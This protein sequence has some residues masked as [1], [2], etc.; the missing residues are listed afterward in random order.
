MV[1]FAIWYKELYQERISIWLLLLH[2]LRKEQ[3]YEC[4]SDDVRVTLSLWPH[5][6]WNQGLLYSYVITLRHTYFSLWW[7]EIE[8][9]KRRT[10]WG[11]CFRIPSERATRLPW[12]CCD[13]VSLSL[14]RGQ[15]R[16]CVVLWSPSVTIL[17]PLNHH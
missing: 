12:R 1:C 7:R 9:W 3:R 11:S 6:N 4:D 2:I 5:R 10:E 13:I 8:S 15:A 14:V 17:S 16:D